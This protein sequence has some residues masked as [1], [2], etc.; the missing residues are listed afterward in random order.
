[1]SLLDIRLPIGKDLGYSTLASGIDDE[2]TSITV[3]SGA[4]F[5][6]ISG[7]AN[8]GRWIPAVIVE[9]DSPAEVT[10]A[11]LQA[12]EH[13]A[14]VEHETAMSTTLEILRGENPL[15]HA[16]GALIMILPTAQAWESAHRKISMLETVLVATMGG[17][18]GAGVLNY[19]AIDQGSFDCAQSTPS[20]NMT[21]TLAP[22][23]CW[24][25]AVVMH[26]AASLALPFVAPS[27]STRIDRI[28]GLPEENRIVVVSGTEGAGAPAV[29]ARHVP[30]W[31]VTIRVGAT[32]IKNI[33][34]ATNGY[35]TNERPF[36]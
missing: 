23:I 11:D 25:D 31:R 4:P 36:A 30:L 5:P 18:E 14:I 6:E 35:L 27:G 28:C 12:G 1:M 13:I 19:G 3:T 21:V 9:A 15:S 22:G 17:G 32:S 2:Q 33:D 8:R 7:S 26:M 24:Y 20:P 16:S 29:P 34:D 10:F